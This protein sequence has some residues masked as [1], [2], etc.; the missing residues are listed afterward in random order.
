[1]TCN[2]A[3]NIKDGSIVW[4]AISWQSI[5]DNEKVVTGYRTSVRDISD[6]KQAEEATREK[7]KQIRLMLSNIDAII[8]EGDPY[9]I[10]YIGGQVEKILGYPKKLWFQTFFSKGTRYT[11]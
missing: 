4:A 1:M 11:P 6:R 5:Y 9:N 8:L 7:E 2:S 3:L 10:Y